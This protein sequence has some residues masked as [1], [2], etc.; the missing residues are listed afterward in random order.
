[1]NIGEA[2]HPVSYRD[3]PKCVS[4]VHFGGKM[5]AQGNLGGKIDG[6]RIFDSN[7]TRF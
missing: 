7:L 6:T 1:M 3:F 5:L 4:I 2:T